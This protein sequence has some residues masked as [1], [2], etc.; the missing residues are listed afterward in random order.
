MPQ[1][2]PPMPPDESW[3][4]TYGDAITLLMAFFVLLMS[5][6]KVDLEVFDAVSNGIGAH[7]AKEDRKS[8]KDHLTKSMKIIPS[9]CTQP[10]TTGQMIVVSFSLEASQSTL[11]RAIG[12][13]PGK[14]R[15]DGHHS[16]GIES[17]GQTPGQI[18]A[19]RTAPVFKWRTNS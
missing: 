7:M 11:P 4:A 5:F 16:P 19:G 3:M 14:L 2:C 12:L 6:A 18:I 13:G 15:S 1:D 17:D 8:E 9:L 10:V